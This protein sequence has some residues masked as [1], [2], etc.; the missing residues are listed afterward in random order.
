MSP[1]T[2]MDFRPRGVPRSRRSDPGTS[3]AAARSMDGPHL[4]H[5][6]AI[7]NVLGREALTIYEIAAR[8]NLS[9]VQVARRVSE[10]RERR[11]GAMWK[12]A[13]TSA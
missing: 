6:R 3:K 9:P 12:S 8:T 5:H 13:V 11:A 1:Q 7:L 2:E 4:A 10:L